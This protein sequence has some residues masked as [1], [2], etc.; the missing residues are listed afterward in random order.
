VTQPDI[1]P[2]GVLEGDLD[3]GRWLAEAKRRRAMTRRPPDPLPDPGL[4]LSDGTVIP[5]QEAVDA[6][7]RAY[8]DHR[9]RADAERRRYAAECARLRELFGAPGTSHGNRMSWPREA[10]HQAAMDELD[11]PDTG[12]QAAFSSPS[13]E[14][15]SADAAAYLPPCERSS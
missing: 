15:F 14:W 8:L 10:W 7:H 6:W 5:G 11:P 12:D 1:V 2:R 9:K 3:F 13:G 4:V